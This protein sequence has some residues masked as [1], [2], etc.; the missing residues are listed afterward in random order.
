[1]EEAVTL[2]EGKFA[3]EIIAV[4][5]GPKQAQETLR[6]ALAMGADK[7]VHVLTD[8]RTDQELQPLAVA[9]LLRAVVDEVGRPMLAGL[10]GWPQAT[11]AAKVDVDKA[12]KKLTVERET[13]TGTQKLALSLPAVV[14]ADLRLNTPRYA[15]LPNIMKAKKKPIDSKD[16]T[17]LLSAAELAPRNSVTQ[18]VDPPPRKS[19]AFVE[20]V[21]EL[22]A[23]LKADGVV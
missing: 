23:K 6:A 20:S 4:S 16:A 1:M 12:A 5:I 18:V 2:K 9:K 11:F 15:T 21:D 7:G 19:G 17:A 22:V 10:L 8:L 3:S 13:D 14:T